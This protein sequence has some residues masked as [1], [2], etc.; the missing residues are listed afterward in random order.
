MKSQ[1]WKNIDR[2]GPGVVALLAVIALVGYGWWTDQHIARLEGEIEEARHEIDRR[3]QV[4]V[5]LRTDI[6]TW[7]AYV[8]ALHNSLIEARIRAPEI[9]KKF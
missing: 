9:P 7:E 5:S 1:L 2:W 3:M 4:E 8:V 6:Q